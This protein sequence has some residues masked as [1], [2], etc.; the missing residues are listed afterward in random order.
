[1]RSWFLSYNSQDVEV[2]QRLGAELAR[3][4]AQA[5][6]FFAP[7]SLRPGAYW[8]PALAKEIAEAAAFVLLI[9][10]NGLG[11]WQTLEYQEAMQRSQKEPDFTV[12][13]VV[14]DGVPAPGLP[15]LTH[16]HWIISADPASESSVGQLMD[17]AAGGG[18][19]PGELWRHTA[20]YRGLSAMTES[21]ADFFFGRGRETAEVAGALATTPDRLALLLGN[22][23]VGKSSLAWAGVLAALLRQDW[24][25][26]AEAAGPWPP[27]FQ[28]SRRWCFLTLKPGAEPVRAL[29]EPFLWIWQF[30]AFDPKRAELLLSWV[31]RLRDGKVGLR[32]LLDATKAR[33]RDE[34]HQSEPPAFLLYIDQGEELYVRAKERE[35]RQFG[36]ILAQGVLD[37]RL[38]TM[39]SMRADF[40]GELQK[41]EALYGSSPDQPAA[42]ARGAIARGREPSR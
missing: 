31:D 36:E 28:E 9:G 16:L 30:E 3:R 17:A 24:P 29:V 19:P 25:E 11:P 20:P 22:S 40:F 32:Y 26:M 37:P 10:K 18:A 1:M 6:I 2:A 27:A 39:M 7:Q 15:F 5:R 14:L 23:G 8:M 42:A 38:R 21:D 35:R 34:L 41:D 4:D 33:Y 12:I 13:P